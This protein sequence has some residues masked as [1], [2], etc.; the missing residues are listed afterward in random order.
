[1]IKLTNRSLRIPPGKQVGD[2]GP[3]LLEST[4]CY[5]FIDRISRQ[6][7]LGGHHPPEQD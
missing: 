1:M 4:I 3:R 5:L 2:H 7:D 6:R